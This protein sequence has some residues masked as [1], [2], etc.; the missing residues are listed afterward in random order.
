MSYDFFSDATNTELSRVTP[1]YG[2]IPYLN[3]TFFSV[4]LELWELVART[5]MLAL[6]AILGPG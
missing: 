4:S 3:F 6:T 2:Q 5:K 1:P